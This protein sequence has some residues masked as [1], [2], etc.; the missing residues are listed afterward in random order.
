MWTN[1]AREDRYVQDHW[2]TPGNIYWQDTYNKNFVKEFSCERGY[3]IKDLSLI[4]AAA[5]LL[6]KWGCNWHFLSMVPMVEHSHA[7]IMG[8]DFESVIPKL[9]DV[10]KVYQP[11]LDQIKPSMF[12]IIFNKNWNSRT[13]IQ[14]N[15]RRDFHPTPTEHLEYL[16]KVLP[17]FVI[18]SQTKLWTNDCEQAV[19]NTQTCTWNPHLPTRF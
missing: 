1:T 19:K 2:V 18:T 11:T 17:E 10:A 6:N 7:V 8:P 3:L 5:E 16:E 14:H 15:G 12:E 13:G 4:S 9:D